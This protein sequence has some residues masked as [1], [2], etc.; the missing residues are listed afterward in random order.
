MSSPFGSVLIIEGDFLQFNNFVLKEE[1]SS[2]LF[3]VVQIMI[4][5]KKHSL[6]VSHSY[7][8]INELYN[9]FQYAFTKWS[10][11]FVSKSSSLIISHNHFLA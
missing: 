9:L 8:P 2:T 1:G 6:H 4:G 7:P 10:V 5:Q 11:N 3:L